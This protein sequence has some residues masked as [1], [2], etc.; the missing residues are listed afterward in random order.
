MTGADRHDD[1]SAGKAAACPSAIPSVLMIDGEDRLQKVIVDQ[2]LIRE[3][4]RVCARCG[5]ACR[6]WV[7]STTRMR[8]SCWRASRRRGKSAARAGQAPAAPRRLLRRRMAPA[9]PHPGCR[10]DSRAAAAAAA[11]PSG[12][13]PDEAYIETARCSTC[14]ECTQL[15]GNMFKY[16]DNQQAYIADVHAGTYAEL[17]EAAENCQVS[18]IHPG[19]PRNRTSPGWKSCWSVPSPSAERRAPRR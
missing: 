6:N 12:R 10:R 18:V 7:A 1:R 13:S 9:P 16:D 3:A 8:R 5:T 15:N 11:A 4:D 2:S 17:V 14:N 19:K